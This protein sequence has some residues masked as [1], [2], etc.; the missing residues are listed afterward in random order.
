MPVE[1]AMSENRA[2]RLTGAPSEEFPM[3]LSYTRII[4]ADVPALTVFYETL[5][6]SPAEAP[7]ETPADYVQIDTAGGASLALCSHRV[8]ERHSPGATEPGVNYC[9]I[10]DVEVDDVDMEY[11]R[12]ESLVEEWVLPPTDQPWGN[13]AAILRDPEGNL[14]NL[15]TRG[16][17]RR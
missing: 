14:V 3:R 17:A 1:Q 7:G 8:V 6:A 13:R 9:V 5:L 11:R 12:L 4:T 10:L 15:F 2:H 16:D